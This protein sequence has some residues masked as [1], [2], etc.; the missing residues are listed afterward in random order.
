M[1]VKWM[2]QSSRYPPQ[3]KNIYNKHL[4]RLCQFNFGVLFGQAQLKNI[5]RNLASEL[6]WEGVTLKVKSSIG[7]VKPLFGVAINWTVRVYSRSIVVLHF[8]SI[9][10]CWG[11]C[12]G[13]T[14]CWRQPIFKEL[15]LFLS[16]FIAA[17]HFYSGPLCSFPPVML[18][19]EISSAAHIFQEMNFAKNSFCVYIEY[20]FGKDQKHRPPYF[21]GNQCLR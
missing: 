8:M 12:D 14:K 21:L 10:R 6:E 19:M 13:W 16:W 7:S 18:E 1:S 17:G 11:N 5:L 15:V 3:K 20:F 9:I 2:P 4:I